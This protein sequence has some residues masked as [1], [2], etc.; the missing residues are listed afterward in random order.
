M[1]DEQKATMK[2]EVRTMNEKQNRGAFTS[3]FI[4]HRSALLFHRSSF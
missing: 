3:S 2:Y 1:N 4:V